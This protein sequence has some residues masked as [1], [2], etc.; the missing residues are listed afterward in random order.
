MFS[1]FF[2]VEYRQ[3][4]YIY[5]VRI[6][7]YDIVFV[8]IWKIYASFR[9]AILPALRNYLSEYVFIRG[10]ILKKLTKFNM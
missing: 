4:L 8:V 9:T 7:G 6:V 5:V 10:Y 1:L 2:L 3:Y